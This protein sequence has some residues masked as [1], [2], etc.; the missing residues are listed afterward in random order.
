ML[1]QKNSASATEKSSNLLFS[2]LS[3]NFPT[4]FKT[5]DNKDTK[6]THNKNGK[7]IRL[8]CVVSSNFPAI[9]SNPG[10]NTNIKAGMKISIK[11]VK[12]NST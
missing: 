2:Y 12:I 4:E 6:D 1:S 3:E 5:P 10:A 7:V 11:T 9:S 8:K